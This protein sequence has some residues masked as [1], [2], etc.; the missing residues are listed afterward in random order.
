MLRHP[1]TSAVNA[2]LVGLFL[3]LRHRAVVPTAVAMSYQTVVAE[4]QWWRALV[5]Q[6]CRGKE[7]GRF[8]GA[9][10]RRGHVGGGVYSNP[11]QTKTQRQPA[12]RVAPS[13]GTSG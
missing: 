12:E 7:E 3:W 5:A 13:G 6:A 10:E 1:A 4:R 8:W 2:L 9:A 11:E